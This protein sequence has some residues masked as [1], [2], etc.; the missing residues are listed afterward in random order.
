MKKTVSGIISLV[1]IFCVCFTVF[2]VNAVASNVNSIV[3]YGSYPQSEVKDTQVISELNSLKLEWVSFDYYANSEIG[4][5]MKYSDVELNGEKYRAVTF[6]SYRPY[7]TT[8]K[9][10]KDR[11]FQDENGYD[12]DV[13]YWFL[14][15]PIEWVLLDSSNGLMMCKML[16]DSQPFASLIYSLG[17]FSY[18]SDETA[19]FYA[20]NYAESDIRE[21]LNSDFYNTAFSEEEK[22]CIKNPVK[23]NLCYPAFED[24]NSATTSDKVFLLSQ[25]DVCN[26]SYGFA[27]NPEY[28]DEMKKADGTD[29]A[30]IQG[31][32]PNGLW[33]LRNPSSEGSHVANA[34]DRDGY[35]DDRFERRTLYF[36][37]IGVRPA[38]EVDLSGLKKVILD[39]N[40]G[41]ESL[42]YIYVSSGLEVSLPDAKKSGY[43][44]V[45]WKTANGT[46]IGSGETVVIDGDTSFIALWE[47]DSTP[48]A[49][50][51]VQST[52]VSVGYGKKDTIYYNVE[53]NKNTDSIGIGVRY[54]ESEVQCRN[55]RFNP[56]TGEGYVDI[57]GRNPGMSYIELEVYDLNTGEVYDVEKIDITITGTKTFFSTILDFFND[58]IYNLTGSWLIY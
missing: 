45:G 39:S 5:F 51:I 25:K 46:V 54:Y 56:E 41:K 6:S 3:Y 48:Y 33:W 16:I 23:A 37:S 21:W 24:Y 26:I 22:T 7:W 55:P 38:I 47:A 58:L 27:A 53:T 4:D 52:K 36:T 12:P 8:A 49:S 18:Y 19:Q 10:Q 1:L 15:E 29:Y 42:G 13:V 30:E 50:I 43:K 14:Y 17:G 34:V 2:A 40:G 35:I 44:F 11:S 32:D 20:N 31:L 57:R 28:T 9:S